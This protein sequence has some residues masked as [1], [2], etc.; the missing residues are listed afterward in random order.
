MLQETTDFYPPTIAN[1]N[2][3]FSLYVALKA[4]AQNVSLVQNNA[5]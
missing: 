1:K 3:N 4:N 2:I 5:P